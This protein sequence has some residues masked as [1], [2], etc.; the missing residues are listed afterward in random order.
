[1]LKNYFTVALRHLTRHRMFSLINIS[2][3]AIGISFSL[4]IGIFVLNEKGV[5]ADLR[6]AGS[7]YILKSKWKVKGMGIE[8]T[9]VGPLPRTLKEKYPSLVANY[10]RYNPAT[11]VI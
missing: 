9:T 8:E 2:C 4:L 1:M 3:L 7:H 6:H 5:N 10:Y 11:N